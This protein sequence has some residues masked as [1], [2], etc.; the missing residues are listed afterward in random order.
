MGMKLVW[1]VWSARRVCLV[2]WE[3]WQSDH[4][5]LWRKVTDM[6]LCVCLT[7]RDNQIHQAT[8]LQMWWYEEQCWL[9]DKTPGASFNFNTDGDRKVPRENASEKHPLSLRS[10]MPAPFAGLGCMQIPRAGADHFRTPSLRSGG[11]STKLKG[12]QVEWLNYLFTQRRI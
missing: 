4:L 3:R 9:Q 5:L 2:G 12:P 10:Y 7:A 1:T 8:W 11:G 6:P